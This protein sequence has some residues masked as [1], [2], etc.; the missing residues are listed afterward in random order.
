MLEMRFLI[1]LIIPTF[2]LGQMYTQGRAFA[3]RA[4][5]TEPE[6]VNYS[7]YAGFANV[8]QEIFIVTKRK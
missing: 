5:I 8:N 6:R 2:C 3:F 4:G 7:L 1:L